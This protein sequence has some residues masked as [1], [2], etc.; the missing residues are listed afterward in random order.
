MD[1]PGSADRTDELARMVSLPSTTR[2]QEDW[3]AVER[4]LG[5]AL[6]GDYKNLIEVVG[7]GAFDGYLLLPSP[8]FVS[9]TDN[10]FD[11]FQ[12]VDY[13]EDAM[14]AP[15]ERG[16]LPYPLYPDPGGMLVWGGTIDGDLLFWNTTRP[17]P[18]TWTVVACDRWPEY[19][20]EFRGSVT[21]FLVAYLSGTLR[22]SFLAVDMG[23]HPT[24][25]E[26][27]PVSEQE[28]RPGQ[29][30]DRLASLRDFLDGGQRRNR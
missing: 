13:A 12:Y 14:D 3:E 23:E 15:L 10:Q 8:F 4:S 29:V 1:L 28:H 25:F 26:A 11:F 2:T 21:G 5:L 27:Y 24:T 19:W 16:E 30:L 6:P 17:D 20:M 9:K 22:P 18:D 7:P